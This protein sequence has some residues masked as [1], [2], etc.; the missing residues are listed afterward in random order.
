M[1]QL[2]KLQDFISRYET[3]IFRYPSQYLRLKRERW[4]LIKAA[5]SLDEGS[6]EDKPNFENT[7]S[8]GVKFAGFEDYD[9]DWLESGKK[10]VL[11][12][13]KHWF[14]KSK[15]GV[16]TDDI[17]TEFD[18]EAPNILWDK[19]KTKEEIK[20]EFLDEIFRFQIN[21]ASST[22]LDRSFVGEEIYHDDVLKYFL[23]HFP[24]NYFLL[25]KPTLFVKK[26]PIDLEIILISPVATFCISIVESDE[27]SVFE[28]DR[29]RYWFETIG[30]KNI[31]RINPLLSLN[32]AESLV[33]GYYNHYNVEMPVH[34]IVLSRTGYIEGNYEPPNTFFV[35]K[36]N[37]S[38]W[39]A[40]LRR[41]PSPIK[42]VQLK[43]AQA[44]LKHTQSTYVRRNEWEKTEDEIYFNDD[45][46]DFF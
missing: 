34:K 36:R 18:N 12:T 8:G 6:V 41:L 20:Q 35:D 10:G 45:D 30:E 32:R 2:I 31:K 19:R 29:G 15:N 46:P 11:G 21:W 33:K 22:I 7:Q 23:Q 39:Y 13:I 5:C 24:D 3:D 14:K 26:A 27:M 37:Y 42:Y 38:D 1:A 43:G 4:E 16:E 40:R 44:L 9:E 25:Y 17:N 28:M